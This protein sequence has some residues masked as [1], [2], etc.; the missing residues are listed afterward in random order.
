MMGTTAASVWE[1]PIIASPALGLQTKTLSTL[2]VS[3]HRMD[4][5]Q[6]PHTKVSCMLGWTRADSLTSAISQKE[7]SFVQRTHSHTAVLRA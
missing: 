5:S 6:L 7:W 4:Q 2:Q 1:P 3:T